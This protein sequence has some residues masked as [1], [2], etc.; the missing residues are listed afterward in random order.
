MYFIQSMFY[1]GLLLS[2]YVVVKM[3]N[4]DIHM[5]SQYC[6]TAAPES[7]LTYKI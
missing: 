5:Q 4:K 2:Q 1:R 7:H 3:A 6:I